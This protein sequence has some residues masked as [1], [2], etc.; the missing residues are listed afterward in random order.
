MPTVPQMRSKHLIPFATF[1]RQHGEPVQRLVRMAGLPSACLDEPE[2]LVPIGAASRFRELA[3]RRS[4]LPNIAFAATQDLEIADLGEFG[5]T[6][7]RAPTLHRLL[8]KFSELVVTQTSHM[9]IDLRPR[10]DGQLSFGHRFLSEVGPGE[11]YNAS[12]VLAWM[13]KIIRLVDPAWSP[14][15]I[16]IHTTA[17]PTHREVLESLGAAPRFEQR[18]TGFLVPASMLA[19][20]LSKAPL[21]RHEQAVE[22]DHLWSMSPSMTYAEAVQQIIRSYASDGWLSIEHLSEI[23]DTSVR[24]LQRRLSAERTTYSNIVQHTRA[25]MASEL[26]ESTDASMAEIANQLGYKNQGDFTRA[27]YRWAGISPSEFRRQR[28]YQ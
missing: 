22:D 3:A 25:E 18:G 15:E 19:L 14:V 2:M 4:G 9:V 27:F 21:T 10:P 11:W 16:C 24:S 20:P 8:S 1:L 28:R 12:Y 17:T 23:A 26:L 7:L 6:L 13:L 5:R